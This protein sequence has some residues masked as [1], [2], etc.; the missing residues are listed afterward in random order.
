MKELIVLN[1]SCSKST[2]L[3]KK[4]LFELL[5]NNECKFCCYNDMKKP[6]MF[7]GRHKTAAYMIISVSLLFFNLQVIAQQL[8]EHSKNIE[9]VLN[10]D[11]RTY[12]KNEW[13]YKEG[14]NPEYA[15]YQ[16]NDS[17]W[18]KINFPYMGFRYNTDSGFYIWFRKYFYVSAELKGKALAYVAGKLPESSEIYL[19]GYLFGK[20]GSMPPAHYY[21][22]PA[23]PKSYILSNGLIRYGEINVIAIRV[24]SERANINLFMPFITN[25][26]DRLNTYNREYIVNTLAPMIIV[27]ISIIVA[28]YFL[29]MFIRNREEHY[30]IYIFLAQVLMAVYSMILSVEYLPFSLILMAKIQ[31][32]ALFIASIGYTFYFQDFFRIHSHWKIKTIIAIYTGICCLILFFA[33]SFRNTMFLIYSVFYF[34]ILVPVNFYGLFLVI[35]AVKKK[36]PYAKI[37]LFGISALIITAFHDISYSSLLH[38]EPVMWLTNSGLFFFILSLFITAANRFVDIKKK[39]EKLNIE[40][41]QQKN[42]FFRFVPTQFLSLLGKNSAV[43]IT[44]G[45][46]S[47]KSMSVLFS[48]IR[49]FASL[50]E[51]MN[52]EDSFKLLNRYLLRMETSI[53]QN[54]GF[55]DKYIGDTIMALFSEIPGV[56]DNRTS[57]DRAVY[58]AINMQYQL[59]DFNKHL[60]LQH[61][62]IIHMGTGINT[63]PLILG[64]VGNSH[65]LDTAVLGDSVRLA[66]RLERLTYY[67]HTRILI[68]DYT[69][70]MLSN[71]DHLLIRELDCIVVKEKRKPV[72]IYEIFDADN[73]EI[74]EQKLFTRENFINGLELYKL[75]KFNE[76]HKI[77]KALRNKYQHDIIFTIYLKR[78]LE[79]VKNPPPADWNGIY[80]QKKKLH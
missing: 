71:P 16:F 48:D 9:S 2:L 17:T 65:K 72:I 18:K 6:L 3:I 41:M 64:T 31:Y 5:L 28:A 1:R 19:N 76:A 66:S 11:Q 33:D 29:L 47:L 46:S 78:C 63:G 7:I 14:D 62:E 43:D 70:E 52:P 37:L 32:S 75:R 68:S 42:A 23:I 49:K 73:A 53:M 4:L 34:L 54:D 59:D 26:I 15:R 51:G 44:L 67:Y 50:S 61:S 60:Q 24:Y 20:S 10:L 55:V 39:I 74:K 79:Y 56:D 8:Q 58:A 69:L 36:I 30:N 38:S 27:F 35:Y 21:G 57:A 80:K 13:H 45:D 22:N 77:F 25:E 12:L 40:L